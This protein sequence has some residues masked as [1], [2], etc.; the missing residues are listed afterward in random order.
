MRIIASCCLVLGMVNLASGV[1]SAQAKPNKLT[2][3]E[4]AQRLEA[5]VRWQESGWVAALQHVEAAGHWGLECGR[6]RDPLSWHQ[7]RMVGQQ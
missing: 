6:W 4:A 5:A 7:P 2:S 1:A 3:N